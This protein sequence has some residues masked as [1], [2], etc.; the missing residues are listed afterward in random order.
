MRTDNGILMQEI[1]DMVRDG[2]IYF[3]LMQTQSKDGTSKTYVQEI[4]FG[5]IE[6]WLNGYSLVEGIDYF[7]DF[8]NV[9]IVNKHFLIDPKRKKQH[10]TVR[11]YGHPTKDFRRNPVEDT[12]WVRY[13]VLSRNNKFDIRDD[14]VMRMTVG[15]SFIHRDDLSYSETDTGIHVRNDLNGKPYCIK[16]IMIPTR[17]IITAQDPY[18]YR[19]RSVDLDNRISDY[20]TQF[21]REPVKEGASATSF[22]WPVYSPFC[23]KIIFDLING[24]LDTEPLKEFYDDNFVLEYTKKYN[25]LLRVDPAHEDH[26]FDKDYM[27]VHPTHLSSVVDLNA[28]QYKFVERVI[29]IVLHNRV[30]LTGF[31]RIVA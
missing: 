9:C 1:D 23:S 31:A 5:E 4:P 21:I 6:V 28:W 7:V 29:K 24:V 15:G 11:Q 12:G 30:D 19:D 2:L 8:P 13:G 25:Y 16:D 22:L 10:I 27:I 26:L 14:R 3:K 17:N 18:A 20:M